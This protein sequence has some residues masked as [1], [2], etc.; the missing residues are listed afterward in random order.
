MLQ[1]SSWQ[2]VMI[3]LTVLVGLAL[4]LP[5]GFYTKVEKHNDATTALA[6]G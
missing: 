3:L 4:A 2:R 6:A 1:M 5:N